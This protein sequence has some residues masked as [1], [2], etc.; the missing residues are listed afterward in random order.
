MFCSPLAYTRSP[1]LLAYVQVS[2]L[3]AYVQ[4]SVLLAYVQVSYSCIHIYIYI[5]I[6]LYSC[7]HICMY[8]C[9]FIY[10]PHI[11]SCIHIRAHTYILLLLDSA[12]RFIAWALLCFV[13][14]GLLWSPLPPAI[15]GTQR[16]LLHRLCL[17]FVA[18]ALL[19]L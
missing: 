18:L 19:V 17:C 3:L 8:I 14:S 16:Y 15:L 2:A 10:T 4:V 5:Y 1:V 7:I 12:S 9:L 13:A 11:Y 6:Y